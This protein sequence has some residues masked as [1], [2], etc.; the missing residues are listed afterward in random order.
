MVNL[1]SSEMLTRLQKGGDEELAEIFVSVRGNI[2]QMI[3][4]RL[5]RRLRARVDASDIVQEAFVRASKGLKS[6]LEA[7]GVHPIVWLRLI[8]KRILAETHRLHF[9]DKRSPHNEFV[10]ESESNDMLV[11]QLADSMHS[12]HANVAHQEIVQMVLKL[13]SDLSQQDREILEMRHTEGMTIKEIATMM[14]I[15]VE[16]TKKRYQRALVRVRQ[17]TTDL[18]R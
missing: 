13:I 11:N 17:L 15:S 8:G 3:A 6:Y 14:E 10:V 18:G 16:A 7:P 4:M 5:D 1:D 12:V 2:K 9:R